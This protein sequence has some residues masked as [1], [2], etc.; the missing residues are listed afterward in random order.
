[1]DEGNVLVG[2][3]LIFLLLLAILAI[4]MPVF[5]YRIRNEMIS[6]NQKMSL[7]IKLI[8][9]SKTGKPIKICPD[10]GTNNRTDDYNCMSCGKAI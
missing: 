10:C 5:V 3:F 2:I 9:A 7:L 1:M 8:S 6:M 4:F